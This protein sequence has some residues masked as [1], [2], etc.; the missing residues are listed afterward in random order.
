MKP[1]TALGDETLIV[2]ARVPLL[3]SDGSQQRDGYNKPL[4]E[5]A[6]V[7][8]PGCSFRELSSTEHDLDVHPTDVVARGM[9]P[10]TYPVPNGTLVPTQAPTPVPEAETPVTWQR[11]GKTYVLQGPARLVEDPAGDLDHIVFITRLRS[12]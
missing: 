12:G 2:N 9:M 4:Y 3:N 11:N 1:F 8:V 10:P 7:A 6:P 5:Y